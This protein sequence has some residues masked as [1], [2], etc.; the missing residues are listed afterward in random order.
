[1][2]I[3]K[4]CFSKGDIEYMMSVC[5]KVLNTM[6]HMIE[7]CQSMKSEFRCLEFRSRCTVLGKVCNFK[8]DPSA[9]ENLVSQYM[10]DK[11]GLV[12]LSVAKQL[13]IPFLLGKFYFDE[14][15]CV[16]SQM[17]DCHIVFGQPWLMERNV[18][19][20]FCNNT[21]CLIW[22]RR[23]LVLKPLTTSESQEAKVKHDVV[24]ESIPLFS[25][26]N[27]S[28]DFHVEK[29][30]SDHFTNH[31]LKEELKWDKELSS[32][33]P[34]VVDGVGSE[35]TRVD[36]ELRAP[37]VMH[38]DSLGLNSN[39]SYFEIGKSEARQH[40]ERSS[41]LHGALHDKSCID[42]QLGEESYVGSDFHCRSTHF[43]GSSCVGKPPW[44]S[45]CSSCG[46]LGTRINNM[47]GVI[48][49][50]VG[51]RLVLESSLYSLLGFVIIVFDPG[52]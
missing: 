24:R 20:D 38:D 8:I 1:M 15:T 36:V 41:L 3:A 10:V 43:V 47:N 9:K 40:F 30:C 29:H 18:T 34:N 52:G 5:K 2:G 27:E 32:G 13:T 45:F 25:P 14:L 17:D 11:L 33:S 22:N 12:P 50:L 26:Y 21:Y 51:V 39:S 48:T 37:L 19:H 23:K 44:L 4:N 7:T 42:G 16:V 46:C 6:D 31:E 49:L 35:A 28:F